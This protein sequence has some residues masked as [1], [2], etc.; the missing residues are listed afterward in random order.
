MATTVA[1]SALV[2]RNP[3]AVALAAALDSACSRR[4]ACVI[5]EGEAGIGK[6]TLLEQARRAA[7][8][9]GMSVHV[10]RGSEAEAT[11]PFGIIRQLLEPTVRGMS[12]GDRKGV[13][14]G[15]AGL[16]APILLDAPA[17]G[18]PASVGVLHGL[19][20]VV[21][22]LVERQPFV[23]AID[24]AH[25]ADEPSLRFA[26]YLARRVDSLPVALLLTRRPGGAGDAF[27]A[28]AEVLTLGPLDEAAV[29]EV[30][31]S[32]AASPLD[33]GFVR[34][35]HHASGGNPFL[36]TELVRLLRSRRCPSV[37]RERVRS[38]S[39]R[40]RRSHAPPAHGSARRRA[41][42]HG[43]ARCSERRRRSIS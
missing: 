11:F 42:S 29:G 12:K 23:L 15:A 40:R 36:L 43:H 9:R 1:S 2:G 6:T 33:V 19:Y 17:E 30:L 27:A 13:F 41:D 25:W 39:S 31:G 24:D 14:A 8:D 32:A 22:A 34:A 37:Q 21:A 7:T 20:W 26:H 28:P 16:A 38:R 35:C 3:E 10:A 5:V 4:G 18:E